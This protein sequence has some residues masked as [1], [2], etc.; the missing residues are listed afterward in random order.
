MKDWPHPLVLRPLRFSKSSAR[1]LR[2][3]KIV[4]E[5]WRRQDQRLNVTIEWCDHHHSKHNLLPL[6]LPSNTHTHT[7][8]PPLLHWRSFNWVNRAAVK[9]RSPPKLSFS[10]LIW[11]RWSSVIISRIFYS[12][13][14][15]HQIHPWWKTSWDQAWECILLIWRVRVNPNTWP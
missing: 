2:S 11:K 13:S 7:P 3:L 15:Y 9:I 12:S 10:W 4:K 8:S 6:P 14:S 5:G 1:S